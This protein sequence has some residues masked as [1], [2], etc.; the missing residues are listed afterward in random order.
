ML[1]ELMYSKVRLNRI[2]II[3]ILVFD[4]YVSQS[5]IW[6]GGDISNINRLIGISPYSYYFIR[7]LVLRTTYDDLQYCNK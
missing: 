7:A 5:P 1:A 2:R 4:S 3:R 6:G